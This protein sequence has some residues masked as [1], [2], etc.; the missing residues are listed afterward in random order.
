MALIKKLLEFLTFLVTQ[1][2]PKPRPRDG[3]YW[4]DGS[5]PWMQGMIQLH[6]INAKGGLRNGWGKIIGRM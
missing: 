1:H 3:G 5:R 2:L 4:M 6:A